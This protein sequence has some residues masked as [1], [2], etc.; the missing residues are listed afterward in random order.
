MKKAML[1]HSLVGYKPF[2]DVKTAEDLEVKKGRAAIDYD[3]YIIVV[4]QVAA[5][6]DNRHSFKQKQRNDIQQVNQT[7]IHYEET[8]FGQTKDS[9]G[10]DMEEMIGTFGYI[11]I[12]E[13]R[14]NHFQNHRRPTLRREVWNSLLA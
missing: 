7:N 3:A 11:S 6:Y 9:M 2:Y 13:S 10:K 12:R 8:D 5:N 1:Q 4:H 14:Q